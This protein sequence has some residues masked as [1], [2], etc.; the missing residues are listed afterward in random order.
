MYIHL[1]LFEIEFELPQ[2]GAMQDRTAQ[3]G[4]TLMFHSVPNYKALFKVLACIIKDRL[5]E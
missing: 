3:L 1:N 4:S 2:I 5:A